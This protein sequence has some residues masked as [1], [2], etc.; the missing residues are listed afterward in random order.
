MV[1]LGRRRCP[2]WESRDTLLRERRASALRSDTAGRRWSRLD[3]RV[4]NYVRTEIR[5]RSYLLTF[6]VR[7]KVS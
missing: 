7:Y 5:G 6:C 2:P 1:F 4:V 3:P